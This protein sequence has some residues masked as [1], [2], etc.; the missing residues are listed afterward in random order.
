M[1][2]KSGDEEDFAARVEALLAG[3]IDLGAYWAGAMAPRSMDDHL[4]ELKSL[5]QAA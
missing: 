1:V 3:E 2:F 4:A 5:Y